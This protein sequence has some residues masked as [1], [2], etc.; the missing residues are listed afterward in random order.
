MTDGSENIKCILW[1][2]EE[3]AREDYKESKLGY[4]STIQLQGKLEMYKSEIQINIEDYSIYIYI[5]IELIEE[6]NSE[7]CFYYLIE[8]DMVQR[9]RLMR[10][11]REI[12]KEATP[13]SADITDLYKDLS[14]LQDIGEEKEGEG[15][16][17]EMSGSIDMKL[18]EEILNDEKCEQPFSSSQLK[19]FSDIDTK[20]NVKSLIMLNLMK[21]EYYSEVLTDPFNFTITFKDLA[22]NNQLLDLCINEFKYSKS[23]NL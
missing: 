22:G 13:R 16:D 19:Y 23:V 1:I 17:S 20:R 21:G 3:G 5:Y 2:N 12:D 8:R 18:L 14:F 9:E 10:K 11:H 4:G 15:E 7:V 6:I